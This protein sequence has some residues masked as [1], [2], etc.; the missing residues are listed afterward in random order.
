MGIVDRE[1]G[2]GGAEG[3]SQFHALQDEVDSQRMAA[4]RASQVG[5]DVVLRA[6]SFFGPLQGD[7]RF[8][9]EGFH[10][11]VVNRRSVDARLLY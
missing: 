8:V 11:A 3:G 1:P 9:G 7:L 2:N 6:D 4:L 10:P 5:T